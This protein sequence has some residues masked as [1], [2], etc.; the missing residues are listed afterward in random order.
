MA[1]EKPISWRR[2]GLRRR[3]ISFWSRVRLKSY[4]IL[5]RAKR[6]SILFIQLF[7]GFIEFQVGPDNQLGL[8]IHFLQGFAQVN[9][10]PLGCRDAAGFH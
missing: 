8:F 7:V 2:S 5:C 10:G 1:L 4:D 6:Q 3:N 9:Y